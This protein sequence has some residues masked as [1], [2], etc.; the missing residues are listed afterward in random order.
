ML[1]RSISRPVTT[2]SATTITSLA[3][4]PTPAAPLLPVQF[5]SDPACATGLSAPF[6][7]L[8]NQSG[9]AVYVKGRSG[10]VPSANTTAAQAYT[11][12]A[13]AAGLTDGTATLTVNPMVRRGTCPSMAGLSQVVCAVTPPLNTINTSI[14][15]FQAAAAENGSN[16][17]PTD[18]FVSCQLQLTSGTA[19]VQCNR[20]GTVNTINI[21]WQVLTAP[22]DATAGGITVDHR[23]TTFT[24]APQNIT[25]PSSAT[26]SSFVLYSQRAPT[27]QPDTD[28]NDMFIAELTGSTNLR[29]SFASNG[30]FAT[31]GY[32]ATFVTQVVNWSGAN[33]ARATTAG[34]SGGSFTPAQNTP[35][36][37]RSFLLYSSRMADIAETG[38]DIGTRR[39]RGDITNGTTLTFDRSRTTAG[40]DIG[41]ISWER[42]EL[43]TNCQVQKVAC[44][45]TNTSCTPG[46]FATA[47]DRTRAVTFASGLGPGGTATGRTDYATSDRIASSQANFAFTAANAVSG[48]RITNNGSSDWVV[49]VV[50]VTP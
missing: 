36:P 19:E 11:L 29:M 38:V 2:A 4:S 37:G 39:L 47:V 1:F 8:A 13:Q 42:V 14:L 3:A 21:N 5:F 24:T 23:A 34:G 10:S 9:T 18:D 45:I 32:A 33:V 35:N 17:N 46:A 27:G 48:T 50:E 15:F 31:N 44:N 22:Y 7:I 49:W 20:G 40:H 25:V 6:D 16:D 12:T 26:G 41:D 43:P 30:T 28:A